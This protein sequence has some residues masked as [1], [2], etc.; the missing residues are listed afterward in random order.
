MCSVESTF[1]WKRLYIIIYWSVFK[2]KDSLFVLNKIFWY[3]VAPYVHLLWCNHKTVIIAHHILAII[4]LVTY[5][6][7]GVCA[8]VRVCVRESVWRQRACLVHRVQVC[9]Y[10][11]V[12]LSRIVVIMPTRQ[13]DNII[14]SV[15]PKYTYWSTRLDHLTSAAEGTRRAV[16]NW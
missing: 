1:V 2:N 15:S 13:C 9:E 16:I 5:L 8:H 6:W 4:L 12:C 10:L 11:C 7:V 3:T 14:A